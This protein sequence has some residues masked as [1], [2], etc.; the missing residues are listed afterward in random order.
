MK[1]NMPLSEL[2]QALQV[3]A[4]LP[5]ELSEATPPQLY[6][7][8]EILERELDR[9]FNKEWHC[10]GRWDQFEAAGSFR[11][12]RIGRDPVIII[13]G[14]D[15]ELRAM[16]NICRHRMATL[17][18]D[19]EGL[20]QSRI[21][22]PSS[23]SDFCSEKDLQWTSFLRPLTVCRSF[24]TSAIDPVADKLNCWLRNSNPEGVWPGRIR[25]ASGWSSSAHSR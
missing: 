13:K 24:V 8:P 3:N 14:K 1:P 19:S 10:V 2:L 15:G 16:S 4:A 25:S 7:S 22:C 21:T 11:T 6:T 5:D 17:V 12:T 18:E 23:S 9:I 20:L